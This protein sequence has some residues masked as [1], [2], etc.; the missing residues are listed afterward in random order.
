MS[1]SEAHR[2]RYH[3]DEW[4]ARRAIEPKVTWEQPVYNAAVPTYQNLLSTTY[5]AINPFRVIAHCDVDAAY[6]QFE[7]S[8]LGVDCAKVPLAVLQWQGLI[9]VNYV[10]RKFGVSRFNCSMEEAKNRCPDLQFVHVA[11]YGPGDEHPQYYDSPSPRTHKI[12]LDLYRRESKKIMEIF[13]RRLEVESSTGVHLG[14]DLEPVVA[15]CWAPSF[16]KMEENSL[17]ED[18]LFE[19]ASIDESFFDLSLYV[20]KQI[21]RRF[22]F[23]DIRKDLE[24]LPAEERAN[25]LNT[26]LPL[27]PLAVRQEMVKKSWSLLGAWWP[28]GQQNY[29]SS[30]EASQ[31]S[32]DTEPFTDLSWVDIAHAIAAERMIAVRKHIVDLLGYTTSAG[33]AGNKALAKLCSSHRKPCSQTLLLPR[34]ALDFLAPLPFRKIRFLGGKL[35]AEIADVW[36]QST[37]GELWPVSMEEMQLKLGASGRWLYDLCRGNDRSEVCRRSANRSMMSSKNFQPVLSTH[38]KGLQWLSIMSSE[39]SLR[40]QEEREEHPLIYP[41]F[42]V[43]RYVMSG[44]SGARSQQTP[45]GFVRNEDLAKEIYSKAEKL[46]NHT[47]G[48]RMDHNVGH[49]RFGVYTLALAFAG[50]ERQSRGQKQLHSFFEAPKR[51]QLDSNAS[52]EDSQPQKRIRSLSSPLQ[53]VSQ[54]N[55]TITASSDTISGTSSRLDKNSSSSH[56]ESLY[57]VIFDQDTQA[58]MVRWAC[59]RCDHVVSIPQ[60]D[61]SDDEDC[62][63]TSRSSYEVL[64]DQLRQEH[65]HWHMAVDLAANM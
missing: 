53:T 30:Q 32:V 11:S 57:E 45:F 65:E 54:Q 4:E 43:L 42:L 27:P 19:K 46:W 7:A 15:D 50:I 49:E 47:I 62:R 33:I 26:P 16:L 36:G 31:S 14:F 55:P 9:A 3:E 28:N 6:A 35:G 48:P 13:Q 18:I 58:D 38:T 20:R 56:N 51:K 64:M 8:R 21:L 25:R 41:R 17:D 22:P 5:E 37:V 40:L 34:H 23:L 29:E 24:S 12:S 63:T 61:E 60:F 10:A 52:P 39:L 59:Q 1:K 2:F 44:T